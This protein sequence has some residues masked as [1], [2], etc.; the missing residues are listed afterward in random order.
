MKKLSKRIENMSQSQTLMMAQK[1]RELKA[2]GI[3]VISMS[4]GEPDFNTPDHVKE[5]A[6]KAID[7]NFSFYSPV[8]GYLDLR[9]AICKKFERENN[10][11]FEPN[12]IVVSNGAK[13]SLAN[14]FM[15]IIDE[16]DEVIVPTPYWVSYYEIIKLAG[17]TPVFV[18]STVDDDF[19]V[20]AKQ[21]EDAITP[22]TKAFLFSSPSNPSGSIYSKEELR[23][24]ADVFAKHEDIIIVSDEIYEHI[25][26]VGKHESIAQFDSIRDRVVIV[27]G[28]SK[29]YAMTGW[30]IGYVAAPLWIA[31][32]C[33]KFQGQFTSG[34]SSIAQKASV[35]A[36][37]SDSE[38]TK[39]MASIFERRRDLI[40]KLVKDIKGIK[41]NIPEG[42]FYILPDVSYFF[43]K[44]DGNIIIKDSSDL[45]LYILEKANVAVVTGDAF[46]VPECIR[47]SY[48]T[49]EDLIEKALIRIKEALLNLK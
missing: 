12:Q 1:S 45:A 25:N 34:A 37:S 2:Q 6:K 14:T 30:R 15:C 17:G 21:I 36:L 22:R 19:K 42:A 5:A 31:K 35:A 10:L 4:L 38:F 20:S 33:E 32:A 7:D 39:N 28:V 24:I 26:F 29:G 8:A 11:T 46:G 27:N 41:Y 16:G 13:Q 9:E 49:S 3:D 23:A 47:I 40:I 18:P 48:A 44:S 43:G